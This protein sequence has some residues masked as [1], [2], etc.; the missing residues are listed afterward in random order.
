MRL[1]LASLTACLVAASV[2]ASALPA[3]T[4]APQTT[5]PDPFLRVRVH[6]TDTRLTVSKTKILRAQAI[7]F[8]VTNDGKLPHNFTVGGQKTRVLKHGQSEILQVGFTERGSYPYACTVNGTKAMRGVIVVQS[9]P[10]AGG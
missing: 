5:G 7:F 3:R 4:Q 6:I 8:H 10:A 1:L 9:P 2:A